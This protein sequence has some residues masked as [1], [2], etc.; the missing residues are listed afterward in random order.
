MSER[1]VKCAKLEREAP[2]ID[3][4]T[5]E[6]RSASKMALLLGGAEVQRRVLDQVS[7]EAWRMWKDHMIMILNEYRLDATDP[8]SNAVLNEHMQAFFF[9]QAREIPNYTP[10][11]KG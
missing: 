9:G 1:M 3:P 6:G 4:S 5:P 7:I 2:A 10:Q 8:S 11:Q